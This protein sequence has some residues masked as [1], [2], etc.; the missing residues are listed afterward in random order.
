MPCLRHQPQYDGNSRAYP[1]GE[2]GAGANTPEPVLIH[3]CC[4]DVGDVHAPVAAEGGEG[5][6]D[7][8][9]EGDEDEGVVLAVGDDAGLALLDG[10]EIVD[11]GCVGLVVWN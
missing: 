9:D 4:A 3:A 10:A 7:E 8:L 6:E 1:N 2:D 5:D 11:L